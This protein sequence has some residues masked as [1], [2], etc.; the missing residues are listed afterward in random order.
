MAS[1]FEPWQFAQAAFLR[2]LRAGQEVVVGN[3][4]Q[5]DFGPP[6]HNFFNDHG[7]TE[8][9]FEGS[10]TSKLY[11]FLSLQVLTYSWHGINMQYHMYV[12]H[13]NTNNNFLEV[14]TNASGN[15]TTA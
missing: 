14:D 2:N 15:L 10:S 4:P 9:A 11:A 13:N 6:T 1:A 12:N 5:E 3:N 7:L 8:P